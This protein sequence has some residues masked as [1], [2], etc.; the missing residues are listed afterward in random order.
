MPP[1][2]SPLPLPLR[3]RPA[4]LHWELHN[5]PEDTKRQQGCWELWQHLGVIYQT[6]SLVFP[7]LAC[8]DKENNHKGLF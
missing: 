1:P 6:S 7:A 5:L 8:I 4:D 2:P 3:P